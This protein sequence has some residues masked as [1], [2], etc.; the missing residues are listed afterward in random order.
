MAFYSMYISYVHCI[1]KQISGKL[2]DQLPE[3]K[4]RKGP[5]VTSWNAWLGDRTLM[6]KPEKRAF[7]YIVY[8]E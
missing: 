1:S 6:Y 4:G 8:E 2:S 7:V 5:T 3:V